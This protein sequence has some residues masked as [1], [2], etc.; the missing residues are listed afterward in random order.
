MFKFI[1][2]ELVMCVSVKAVILNIS[3]EAW[4]KWVRDLGEYSFG[5]D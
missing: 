5:M 4:R 1:Y 2:Y 3:D